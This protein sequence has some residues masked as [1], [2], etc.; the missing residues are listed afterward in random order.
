MN[1]RSGLYV[2]PHTV[3]G[4][5]SPLSARPLAGS[6]FK[7]NRH[8]S[9]VRA[10][11]AGAIT[12]KSENSREFSPRIFRSHGGVSAM[13]KLRDARS[14]AIIRAMCLFA[15]RLLLMC[16]RVLPL[17]RVKINRARV[18]FALSVYNFIILR[19]GK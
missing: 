2:S 18:G 13:E 4:H 17:S 11:T 19:S 5:A 3:S 6:P 7:I 10:E 8:Y 15:Y 12:G 9:A 14:F 16:S 1:I